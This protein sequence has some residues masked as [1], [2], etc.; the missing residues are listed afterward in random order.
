MKLQETVAGQPKDVDLGYPTSAT[1]YFNGSSDQIDIPYATD[2][3]PTSFTVEMW[4][5]FQRSRGYRAILTSVSGSATLG[6]RGYVFCVNAAQQWQFWLGSGQIGIPWVILTGSKAQR[7][8]WTHLT[9]TYDSVSKTMAFYINGLAV[10]QYTGIPFQPNN[11][12]PLH[13][14]AGATEAGASSCFFYGS[15]TKVRIWAEALSPVEIQTLAIEGV[16]GD[17]TVEQTVEPTSPIPTPVAQVKQPEVPITSPIPTPVAQTKQPEVTITPPIPTPV[18]QTKQPEVTI[19]S[20]IPTPVAQVKQPE[21]PAKPLATTPPESSEI[22]PLSKELEKS[23]QPVLMF[24][25]QDD[26]VEIPYS[27]TLDFPQTQDFAIEVWLKPDLMEE[28]K[29][30]KTFDINVLEKWVGTPFPYAIRYSSKNGRVYASRYDDH[31]KNPAVSC[32]QPINDQQFHHVAFV[33]QS[34]QL[35]LYVDGVE[36]ATTNDTTIGTTQNNSP[37]YLSRGAVG[38]GRHLFKGQMVEF[39]IWNRTRSQ[40]EIQADMSRH[41]VGDEPGLVGYWALNEGSGDTVSDKTKNA[42]HGKITGATW[43]QVEVPIS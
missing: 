38:G 4:V 20:P 6:R 35:Y 40:A 22:K 12:H 28:T 39:R 32:L 5:L 25:G 41:L 15:I 17:Q 21:V 1:P 9:G 14:G 29:S 34:S 7:G 27:P 33:K 18:A 23:L 31:K 26:Y 16:L 19:T 2:I 8:I 10:G 3:N 37:L 11:R 42:N 13:V 24:D 43:K 30:K 36:V